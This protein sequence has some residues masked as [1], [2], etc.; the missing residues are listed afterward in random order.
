MPA[1]L[2]RLCHE[3]DLEGVGCHLAGGGDVNRRGGSHGTTGLMVAARGG[4]NSI[5]ALLVQQPGLEVDL[6][7]GQGHTA[8]HYACSGGN[9]AGLALLLAQ[10]G[11]SSI[12]ARDD[13]KETA[14]MT[15]V[16][17]GQL[18]CVEL[19]VQVPGVELNCRDR[20]SQ[21]LASVARRKS[22]EIW[23]LVQGEQEKRTLMRREVERRREKEMKEEEKR[24]AIVKSIKEKLARVKELE[25]TTQSFIA[26]KAKE[27][28]ILIQNYDGA[29]EEKNK[30]VREIEDI[31]GRMTRLYKECTEKDLVMYKLKREMGNLEE[32]ISMRVGESQLEISGL[33]TDIKSLQAHQMIAAQKTKQNTESKFLPPNS[34]Y[35][36]SIDTKIEAKERELECPVC[37][38]VASPPIYQG[39]CQHLVCSGCRPRLAQ[40]PEC[41]QA[42]G[43][44]GWRRHRYAE[45]ASL[46]LE[47]LRRERD[48]IIVL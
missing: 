34:M 6:A 1:S 11:L 36:R 23:R 30:R 26:Y 9:T 13:K 47:D 25:E 10:P 38:E 14:L 17:L 29:I 15:A 4:H 37:L 12:D 2:S 33:E 24:N 44:E 5:L 32:L 40:C 43:E 19:L 45:K 42:Y 20:C 3:G 27:M 48:G 39:L 7:D 22:L 46:D 16:K 35:L 21:S 8:L 41:R 28:N 18:G 31:K